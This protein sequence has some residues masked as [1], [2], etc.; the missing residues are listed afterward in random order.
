[1]M[2][3]ILNVDSLKGSKIE[4]YIELGIKEKA[5]EVYKPRKGR[6]GK[7][8]DKFS[9]AHIKYMTEYASDLIK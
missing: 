3:F 5:P 8:N 2:K 7:N 9:P 4:K 6:V 1:M